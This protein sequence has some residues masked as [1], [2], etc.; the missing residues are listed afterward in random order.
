MLDL[1]SFHLVLVALAIVLTAGA[2]TWGVLNGHAALG[3]ISLAVGVVL[4]V[5]LAY[6]AGRAERI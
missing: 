3:T 5:Y 4:V 6:F 1:K 2:G